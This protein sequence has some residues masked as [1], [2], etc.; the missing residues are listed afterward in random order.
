M[1]AYGYGSLLTELFGGSPPAPGR[2]P[3]TGNIPGDMQQVCKRLVNTNPKMRPSVSIVLDQGRRNGAYF[4][5]PLI[6]FSENIDS[7]GLKSEGERDEF[8]RFVELSASEALTSDCTYRDLKDIAQNFPDEYLKRK[9]LPELL[10]SV[11]FGGGGPK[12]FSVVLEVGIK[13]SE[14]EYEAQLTPVLVRLFSSPDR[15]LR[16]CL[17]ES[18]PEMIDHLSQKI[19]NDRIFPNLVRTILRPI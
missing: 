19:V 13:L 14:E 6:D 11:E 8:L 16:L 15:A 12:V 5:T 9:L 2:G 18:L 7:L 3:D 4:H 10:K 1:D 17:L